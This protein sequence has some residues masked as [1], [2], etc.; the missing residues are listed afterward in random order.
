MGI[1]FQYGN[2][3]NILPDINADISFS[4]SIVCNVDCVHNSPLLHSS[5]RLFRLF[6]FKNRIGEAP[7]LVNGLDYVCTCQPSSCHTENLLLQVWASLYRLWEISKN[8]GIS[9]IQVKAAMALRAGTALRLHL[10]EALG[11]SMTEHEYVQNILYMRELASSDL[12]DFIATFFA[13]VVMAHFFG[14]SLSRG[15]A[16]SATLIYSSWA[17]VT[18]FSLYDLSSSIYQM[19]IELHA[20]FPNSETYTSQWGGGPIFGLVFSVGP[21]FVSW[22]LSIFFLH[23]YIRGSEREGS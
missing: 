16:V 23:I 18:F 2:I 17:A 11:A 9:I 1:E 20:T 13:Y 15:L 21:I 7:L 3:E 12:M 4:T 10:L 19:T 6:E 14:R 8:D 22:L 5:S